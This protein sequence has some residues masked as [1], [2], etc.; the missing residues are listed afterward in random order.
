MLHFRL[1][2]FLFFSFFC[3]LRC[4]LFRFNICIF[5]SILVFQSQQ[6]NNLPNGTLFQVKV[7]YAYIPVHDDELTINPND[8]VNVTRLVCLFISIE[9]IK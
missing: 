6:S 7:A 9:K 1:I 8:I 2:F 5:F 4:H 3:P